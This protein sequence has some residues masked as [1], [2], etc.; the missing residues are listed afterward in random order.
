MYD[1]LGKSCEPNYLSLT[2]KYNTLSHDGL[3]YVASDTNGTCIPLKYLCTVKKKFT[4]ADQYYY[5]LL[6]YCYRMNK[7]YRHKKYKKY[8]LIVIL[9]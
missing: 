9:I 7:K 6:Y 2:H 5:F 4:Y 1:Q 8:S 3:N